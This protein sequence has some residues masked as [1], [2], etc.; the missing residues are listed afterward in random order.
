LI[1][2]ECLANLCALNE[3]FLQQPCVA[4]VYLSYALLFILDRRTEDG[5]VEQR[6]G[7]EQQADTKQ[8]Q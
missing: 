2:R 1:R 5:R 6:E 4:T 7:G 3:H 8:G